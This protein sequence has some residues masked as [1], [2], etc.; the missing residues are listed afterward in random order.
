MSND[1]NDIFRDLFA[2]GIVGNIMGS[3]NTNIENCYSTMG[4]N[5]KTVND[6]VKLVAGGGLVAGYQSSLGTVTRS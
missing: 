6:E 3:S 4:I 1:T 5:L 2:G